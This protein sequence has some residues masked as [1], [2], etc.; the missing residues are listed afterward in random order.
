MRFTFVC[1]VLAMT[2]SCFDPDLGP[3]PFRCGANESCPAGYHCGS[4]R[5][6]VKG[7]STGTDGGA[8]IDGPMSMIDAPP[9]GPPD[10]RIDAGTPD[11]T[12]LLDAPPCTAGAVLSCKDG[13]TAIVCAQGGGAIEERC[14][15]GCDGNLKQCNHCTPS[16]VRCQGDDLVTCS[17]RGEIL[18]TVPCAAGCDASQSLHACFVLAPSLLPADTCKGAAPAPPQIPATIDTSACT[19][20]TVVTQ[21]SGLP[22][23]CV[24]R[25][26]RL[27]LE[28]GKTLSFTGTRIPA[29]V[30][31][32]T[33]TID[34]TIDVAAHGDMGGVASNPE[35]AGQGGG[36]GADRPEGGGGGGMLTA[37]GP[38]GGTSTSNIGGLGG[39]ALPRTKNLRP[40]GYGGI[41]GPC[42]L[43]ERVAGG[44]GGGGLYLVGCR[45]MIIG[46]TARISAG[47]GGGRGGQG[48]VLPG[49][50]DGGGAGGDV[51]LEATEILYDLGSV[52]AANGGGG[53]GGSAPNDSLGGDRGQDGLLMRAVAAGG[54]PNAGAG[55]GGDGG[56][57]EGTNADGTN[58]AP[59]E[60]D[61][62]TSGGGGGGGGSAGRIRLF[63]RS[64]RPVQ[65]QDRVIVSPAPITGPIGRTR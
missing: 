40:G 28:V 22:D 10:A 38:G 18:S 65:I 33:I 21:G 35:G 64:D 4:G 6:C 16:Q 19:G 36:G 41:G 52:T 32:E 60:G 54:Q 56:T 39:L 61:P 24:F 8:A 15:A 2:G 59:G 47:G 42:A 44:G 26:A 23:L 63:T 20:G 5:M 1:F 45:G 51:F 48:A 34:G 50:G 3:A 9:P 12:I 7:G 29:F 46:A 55:R 30:A 11:A 62:G 13:N 27:T 49:G 43:C 31:L 53:G 57:G 17:A 58:T 25:Y 14:E 37:G